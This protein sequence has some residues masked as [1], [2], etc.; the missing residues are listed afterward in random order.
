M[1]R[2]L[3]IC[4]TVAALLPAPAT[5]ELQVNVRTSG[6]QTGAA[7]AADPRG[8]AMVVWSCFFSSGGRSH[9]ILARRLD[10][11][12]APV[13]VEFPVNAINQGNQA[14]PAVAIDAAGRLA[15]VWQSPGPEED[16]LMRMY[17]PHRIPMTGDLL[18]NLRT[19]GRQVYPCITAGGSNTFL[20]AW[21]SRE[22][23]VYGDQ[24]FLCAQ[25]FDP[26]GA[27]VA[28][29][30]LVDPDIYDCRYPDAAMDARGNFVVTWMRD[31]S[32]HPI[33][34]RLFDAQGRPRTEPF[35][36]NTES[37]ASVTRPSVAMNSQGWFL[38]AWDGDPNRAADDDVHA[39]LYDPNGIPRGEPFVVNAIRDGA[40][41]WPQA[42]INDANEFVIVWE[43]DAG[44]P[45]A[46]TDIYA[47][48][49]A[50]DGKP[51]G[52]ETRL[53]TYT[54]DKQRYA[55]VAMASDGTFFAVWE[56]NNQDG[57][58]YGVFVHADRRKDPSD[59]NAA[60][61]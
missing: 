11:T 20:A 53:N 3:V 36:V 42:A 22:P 17:D 2:Y 33:L 52:E 5:A 61:E 26:N 21:E 16:V 18:L 44:D 43:Y 27:G 15:I 56:S 41:Q 24:T 10:A 14:E 30:I 48:R 25:R 4:A 1:S 37:V 39:R 60:T 29:E 19:E 7:I 38:I 32:S 57:S 28:D 45:N 55:D 31:R 12:G 59:R 35:A 46:G 47:R 51:V 13:G 49:F 58:G 6:A 54:L 40:Q 9:D 50:A 8:G 23:T 34:A